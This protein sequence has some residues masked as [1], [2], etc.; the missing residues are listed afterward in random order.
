MNTITPENLLTQ[1]NWRYATKQFDPQ[2]KIAPQ[3]WAALEETLLLTPSSFGLQPWKFLVVTDAATRER[4]VPVSW[5]QRQVAD[6]S[7]LVV[8]AVKRNFGEADIDA[9]L[10]R[11]VDVR[12]TSRE[13]LSGYRGMMVG[14]LIQNRDEAGRKNWA[15]NQTYIALGNFLTSAALLGVDACPLEGIEPLKYDELLGLKEQGLMTVVAAAAGYR[16]AGD[17]Y[18]SARKVRFPKS[19][20]LA[21][22]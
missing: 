4:L 9:Y 14:N 16:A 1:L 13:S 19:A 6:A 21:E 12:G 20:V 7:H 11:I 17:K 22:I 8:F 3:T 5:G 18:A 10:N 15:T 2:L